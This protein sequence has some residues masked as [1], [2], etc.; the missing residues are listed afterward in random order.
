MLP[1][2]G[3]SLKI[4]DPKHIRGDAQTQTHQRLEFLG[5]EI[6]EVQILGV[7]LKGIWGERHCAVSCFWLI[8]LRSNRWSCN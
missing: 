2:S 8:K 3:D 4:T 1:A 5:G 6:L 7:N